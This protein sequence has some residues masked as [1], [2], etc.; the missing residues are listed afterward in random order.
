MGMLSHCVESKYCKLNAVLTYREYLN[1]YASP[2]TK[3]IG[4]ELIKKEM[5]EIEGTDYFQKRPVLLSRFREDY[6]EIVKGKRDI[7]L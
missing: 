1:D 6:S 4:E 3:A 2:A 7:Y 5:A